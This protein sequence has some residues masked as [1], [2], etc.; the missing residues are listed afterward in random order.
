M[1]NVF[2]SAILANIK[3]CFD[4]YEHGFKRELKKSIRK[5]K[6]K[7]Y[8]LIKGEDGWYH[9]LYISQQFKEYCENKK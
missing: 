9:L 6:L 5:N 8:L 4:K 1:K 2:S 3:P 7:D